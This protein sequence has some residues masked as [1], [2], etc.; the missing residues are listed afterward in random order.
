MDI[1]HL[2]LPTLPTMQR[3]LTLRSARQELLSQNLANAATPG[4]EAVDLSFEKSMRAAEERHPSALSTTDRR[5]LPMPG[6][7]P[8]A[9]VS[10]VAT[11][12]TPGLDGNTVDVEQTMGKMAENTILYGATAQLTTGIFANL[13]HA[14][15]EGK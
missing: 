1:R 13:L 8:T 3:A 10:L 6:P 2:L 12:T 9:P 14:I 7:P 4:Y 15:R 11:G 5:H